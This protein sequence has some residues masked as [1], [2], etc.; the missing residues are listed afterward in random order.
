MPSYR[1]RSPLHH[2]VIAPIDEAF[3]CDALGARAIRVDQAIALTTV[4]LEEIAGEPMSR[5]I[6]SRSIRANVLAS[7]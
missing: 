6:V 7:T 5:H 4:A 3:K 1:V 2:P